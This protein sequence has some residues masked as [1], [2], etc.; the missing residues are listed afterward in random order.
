VKVGIFGATGGV[1]RRLTRRLLQSPRYTLR[2]S[3]RSEVKIKDLAEERLEWRR[4][5]LSHGEE[6]RPFLRGIDVLVYL[7]HSLDSPDFQEKDRMFAQTTAQAA[8]EA[9]VK[10]IIYLGGIIPPGQRLSPHLL[11]REETGKALASTGLPVGELRASIILGRGSVSTRI[12]CSLAGR[13]PLIVAPRWINS[14]CSPI[15]LD[16]VVEALVGLLKRDWDGH[17]IF[18]VGSDI[19]RYQDLLA[20]CG[21]ILTGRRNKIITLPFLGAGLT[22][23]GAARIAAVPPPLTAALVGSLKNDT[24]YQQNRFRELTGRDPAPVKEVLV[25]L[26]ADLKKVV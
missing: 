14:Y 19:L 25:K 7:I 12:L 17:E 10:K 20:L 15:G 2:A 5:D 6:I 21:E 1:G 8:K 18:E 11:S 16:D 4:L 24:V 9:R 22:A 26:A 23:R 13:L 3:Y